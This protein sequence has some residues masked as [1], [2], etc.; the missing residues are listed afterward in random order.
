MKLLFDCDGTI[1]DSMHIWTEPI[2][3][4]FEKYGSSYEKLDLE[5][6]GKIEGLS[7]GGTIDYISENIAKDMTREEVSKYF[8]DIIEDGYRNHLMPK[9]GALEILE[10]LHNAGFEMAIASSTDSDYLKLAFDRLDIG[11]YFSFLTTPDLININKSEREFWQYAIDKFDVPADQIILY[12]DALYAIKAAN[13]VG[14]KTCGLKDFPYNKNQWEYI[15][16]NAD[17]VLDTIAEININEL[18][19]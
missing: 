19:A 9:D 2:D 4:I 18:E 3:K 17:E 10:K 12:D 14:I 15:I 6:K 7:M 1:L 11:K 13:S 8:D 16:E 5:E